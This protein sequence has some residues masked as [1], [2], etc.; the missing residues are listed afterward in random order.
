MKTE[1]TLKHIDFSLRQQTWMLSC[2][3]QEASVLLSQRRITFIYGIVP[4]IYKP[5]IIS[6]ISV[7]RQAHTYETKVFFL[8]SRLSFNN[9]LPLLQNSF[10]DVRKQG[11]PAA[12][13]S[14]CEYV[15]SLCK[16]TPYR[17]LLKKPRPF[18]CSLKAS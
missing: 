11:I 13:S 2:I 4:R 8:R 7:H 3:L 9:S 15:R 6:F 10:A 5:D 14:R 17:R 18:L 16:S 1:Y 12:H